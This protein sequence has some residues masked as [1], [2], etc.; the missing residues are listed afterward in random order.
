MTAL[1][2]LLYGLQV[3]T[4]PHNLLAA[5]VGVL[6]G[7]LIGVLP[8]LGPVAGA[9]LIL[10][11]T[12]DLEPVTGIIMIAGI[13]YGAQY[14][15]STTAVLL[16]VPGETSSVVTAIDGHQLSRRGRAGPVL[17]VMA[18][19]SFIAGTLSIVLVMFF[20]PVL[21]QAGILFG[22]A[23]F[24]ALTAGGLLAFSRISGGSLVS[25]LLPLLLGIMLGTVGQESVTTQ[26]RFTF[27]SVDLG[28]GISL[29]P[30]AVGLFGVSEML[31]LAEGRR[32][33]Q[34]TLTVRLRDLL[35]SRTEL[36]RSV[37]AWA[38][39]SVVGFLFG[40]L[41]GPSASMSSFASYRLEK[42]VSR[43]RKSIGHGAIEGVAG[44]EAANNSA[45]T[46]SL[47]PVLGLGI[48]FSATLALALSA[49]IVQG[50]EP[51]PLLVKNNP[52]VFWG[53][54]ASMYIGNVLLVILNLPLVGVWV[55]LLKCP[56]HFLVPVV[57]VLAVI[58]SFSVSNS[59]L[60]VLILFAM[61]VVGYVLRRLEFQLVPVVLGVVLGPLVETYLRESLILS[62]GNL[63]ILVGS[64]V[65]VTIWC[66]VF[67]VVVVAPVVATLRR[68]RSP[69]AP[70]TEVSVE[71]PSAR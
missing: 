56:Q 51:G 31:L 40:L 38:R 37:P 15:G 1:D 8:G 14:G 44:P 46:S 2:G 60:D 16:N 3:A 50:V 47:I 23:E 62:N 12:F 25:N 7:T 21:S 22:P 48:P 61:G 17:S 36:R 20:T 24:F 32:G 68:R 10:P 49:L 53:V 19:G 5:L 13:Y 4:Q 41:P 33:M 66:L 43:H 55:K 45:A 29:V 63:G 65:S 18:I 71:S 70:S 59:M 26:F 69:G 30:V 52:E 67:A 58:G 27:G 39:G 11:L 42:A 35:P 6:A 34:E 64:P 57:L 54:I 28:Q 9:A